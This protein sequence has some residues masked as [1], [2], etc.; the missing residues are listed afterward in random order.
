MDTHAP[1]PFLIANAAEL[2]GRELAVSD[3]D[4]VD[5]ARIDRFAEATHHTH[6]LHTDPERAETEGPY[7]GTVAHGFFML[8][9]L[10]HFID[11]CDLRPADSAFALNY[12]VDRV[13]FL[14]PVP[15]GDGFRVRDRITLM[16]TEMRPKGLFARTGHTLEVEGMERPAVVA[17]YLAVWVH[18]PIA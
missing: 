18:S 15:I 13:R 14:A 17:E 12:G 2:V 3:W 10:N 4:F 1:T 9:L 16:E 8:S 5:Q 11:A 6:W 7:G